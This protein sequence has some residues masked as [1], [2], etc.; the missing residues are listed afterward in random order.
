MSYS[1]IFTHC[2]ESIL[3]GLHHYTLV[4][5]CN[6]SGEFMCEVMFLKQHEIEGSHETRA[7]STYS[8]F[9]MCLLMFH[10]CSFVQIFSEQK[11]ILL[12]TNVLECLCRKW[13]SK[14][15][16]KNYVRRNLC[17]LCANSGIII[18]VLNAEWMK[19]ERNLWHSRMRKQ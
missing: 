19:A 5:T 17:D 1:H 16:K 8:A 6:C 11:I 12:C 2:E 14:L 7:T 13:K 15:C 18:G 3:K 10:F 9:V 4:H